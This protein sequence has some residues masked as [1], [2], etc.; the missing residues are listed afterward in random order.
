MLYRPSNVMTAAAAAAAKKEEE[1]DKWKAEEE[2]GGGGTTLII[3]HPTKT[4]PTATSSPPPLALPFPSITLSSLCFGMCYLLSLHRMDTRE[5]K[6]RRRR[7]LSAGEG[8]RRRLRLLPVFPLSPLSPLSPEGTLTFAPRE[9]E[10]KK[11]EVSFPLAPSLFFL[12]LLFAFSGFQEERSPA[13]PT[14]GRPRRKERKI[15]P[16]TDVS[17]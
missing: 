11:E 2:R 1:E 14:G 15:F 5:R 13:H 3:Y 4:T 12:L 17:P 8:G 16:S 7:I 9:R 10:R 6:R